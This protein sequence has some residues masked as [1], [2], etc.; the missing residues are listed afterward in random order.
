MEFVENLHTHM[1]EE[2]KMNDNLVVIRFNNLKFSDLEKLCG[3]KIDL[4]VRLD[5]GQDWA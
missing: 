1:Q 3:T 4:R 5:M 2:N